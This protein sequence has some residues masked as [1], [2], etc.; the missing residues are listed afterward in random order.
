MKAIFIPE[1]NKV[2]VNLVGRAR[3]NFHCEDDLRVVLS[4]IIVLFGVLLEKVLSQY[5][6]SRNWPPTGPDC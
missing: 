6:L 4:Y 5:E 2:F 3:S 1:L